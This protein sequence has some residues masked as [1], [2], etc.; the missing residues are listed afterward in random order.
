MLLSKSETS[1]SSLQM[2]RREQLARAVEN[3]L[4]QIEEE[5]AGQRHSR[6]LVRTQCRLKPNAHIQSLVVPGVSRFCDRSW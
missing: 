6:S 2:L 1:L 5:Q 3:V 4:Q